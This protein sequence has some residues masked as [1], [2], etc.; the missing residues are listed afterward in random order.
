LRWFLAAAQRIRQAVP[1]VRFAVGALRERHAEMAREIVE[2]HEMASRAGTRLPLEIYVGKT[3]EL[4][5]SAACAMA[6]SG[7]VS[8]SCCTTPCR[9]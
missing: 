8:L 5:S 3:P 6:C 1:G 2:R 7:S 4:M 9:R